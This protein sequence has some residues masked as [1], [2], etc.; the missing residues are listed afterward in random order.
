MGLYDALGGG[1]PATYQQLAAR[2]GIAPRYA[3][4]WLE[5]QAAAAV[6]EV[7]DSC[8]APQHRLYALPPGHA[9][10]LTEPESPFYIASLV[11]IP[12]GMSA[13]LGLLAEAYQAGGG[14]PFAAFSE[15]FRDGQSA[16][17]RNV[18]R[19]H[20]A[21][22][23]E[24]ALPDLHCRLK[25]PGALVADI[26][27]GAGWS[28]IALARA[29]PQ[30]RVHAIDADAGKAS[31]AEANAS[32]SGLAD[33]I[34]V[35]ICATPPAS[36]TGSCVLVGIFDALHDM[37]RPVETLAACRTLLS[38]GG[39]VLLMEPN[40]ADRFAAPANETERFLYAASVLHCLPVG[41]SEQP[42]A[43]TGALLRPEILRGYAERAGFRQVTIAPVEHRFFRVY[44]LCP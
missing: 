37:A 6:I 44:S 5:Q 9:E 40:A 36:L 19:D 32:A 11:R 12:A 22:W 27:C 26:G 25:A 1:G 10:A 13:A 39:T 21:H 4:E 35:H 42:S 3:R 29:Y 15:E 28:A 24:Q 30:C 14:V 41:M 38:A 18:F 20:L 17:N 43:A 31:E 7:G 34:I 8:E 16:L 33:R 23:I 2:A